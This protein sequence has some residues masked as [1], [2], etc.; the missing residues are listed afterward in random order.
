MISRQ[1]LRSFSVAT[2]SSPII[3]L[4]ETTSAARIVVSFRSIDGMRH[5]SILGEFTQY[6]TGRFL[7]SY[8]RSAYAT[9]YFILFAVVLCST[10]LGPAALCIKSN[11]DDR[12][13]IAD[14]HRR[15]APNNRLHRDVAFGSIDDEMAALWVNFDR[16]RRRGLPVNVRLVPKA[17]AMSCW[18]KLTAVP[19]ADTCAPKK[20]DAPFRPRAGL[21]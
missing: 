13:V 14:S 8:L 16:N 1:D 20:D 7:Q 2:S 12:S 11:P 5:M 10:A 3:L 19:G 18:Q 9:S 6:E 17:T 4:N 15:S 21:M